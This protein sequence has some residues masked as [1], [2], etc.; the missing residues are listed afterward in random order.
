ML[1]KL[2]SDHINLTPFSVTRVRLAAQVLSESVGSVLNSFGPADAV[3]T[4][5]CCLMMD[6]LFV[7]LNVKNTMEYKVKQNPFL[8][9]Y[10]SVDDVRFASSGR[11][12]RSWLFKKSKI[13]K[14]PPP[15][16]YW[17]PKSMSICTVSPALGR[18]FITYMICPG[19]GLVICEKTW[20]GIGLSFGFHGVHPYQKNI[21]SHPP[22]PPHSISYIL[23]ERF[24]RD[25]LEN[26]F[27]RQCAIG[28]RR[29]N[30]TVRDNDNDNTIKSQY[31]VRP[32]AGNVRENLHKFNI[33]DERKMQ[34]KQFF[35]T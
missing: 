3:G 29:D 30:P 13:N 25:D 22:P 12:K 6:N 5:K 31:S 7:C 28:H 4:A 2:T 17:A 19:F 18:I 11:N 1:N 8:K 9:P 27:G 23:F 21:C 14:R 26:Y 33:I 35:V 34:R 32:I 24:C 20:P 10:T 15:P 16:V